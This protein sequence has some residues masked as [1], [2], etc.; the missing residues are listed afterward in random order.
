MIFVTVGTHGQPFGRL[1]RGLERLPADELVVQYGHAEP[2]HGVRHAVPFMS[3]AEVMEHLRAADVVITHAGVGSILCATNA[4]HVPIVVP[5]LK[6]FREHV[7]DHQLHLIGELEGLGRV[8]VVQDV[9]ELPAVVAETPVRGRA[10][11][12]SVGALHA[13]VRAA[14]HGDRA[15]RS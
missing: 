15:L 2:P 7:D 11:G 12:S 13:A 1:V 4:G 6:R 10:R 14:M 8:R 3:F 5:R 9:E